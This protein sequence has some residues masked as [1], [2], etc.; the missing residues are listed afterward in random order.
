MDRSPRPAGSESILRRMMNGGVIKFSLAAALV[1][2]TIITI[3][4]QGD[5]LARG[6]ELSLGKVLLTYITLYC[7]ATYLALTTR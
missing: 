6:D 4:N 7:M 3:I 1:G 5:T 2:G